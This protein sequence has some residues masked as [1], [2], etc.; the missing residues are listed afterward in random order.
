MPPWI[1]QCLTG[2]L[3]TV[4][5]WTVH[6]A[7]GFNPRSLRNFPMQGNGNEML[8]LACCFATERGIEISAPIHDAVLVTAPL[9]RLDH[10]V[11]VTRAAM[12]E[13]SRIV[14]D[15]FEL[16]TDVSIVRFPDRYSDSR[17]VVMWDRVMK[18]IAQREGLLNLAA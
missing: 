2:S 1:T 9:D 3:S 6:V 16:R 15:G 14:L 8:R 7:A 5:G 12:A 18:L 11:A 13:A 17:G 4:F 10:D